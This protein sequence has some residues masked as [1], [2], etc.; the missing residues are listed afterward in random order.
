MSEHEG[1]EKKPSRARVRVGTD[2]HQGVTLRVIP[3]IPSVPVLAFVMIAAASLIVHAA[4]PPS[5]AA[6]GSPV[7]PK[8]AGS[9]GDV[10]SRGAGA[11]SVEGA[12][13]TLRGEIVDL[14]C[15]LVHEGKGEEHTQCAK[16]CVAGGAPVGLLADGQLYVLFAPHESAG[17]FDEAKRLAG[18][19]AE[20]T[21]TVHDRNGL[22]GLAVTRVAGRS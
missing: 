21:G 10:N 16:A 8:S 5:S 19:R 3:R 22:R 15:Y 1:I 12:P 18:Q 4:A 13:V 6:H 20:V 7:P 9:T 14:A 2:T 11:A 17:P